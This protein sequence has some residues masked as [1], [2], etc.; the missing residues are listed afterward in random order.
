MTDMPSLQDGIDQAGSPIKLLWKPGLPGWKPPVIAEEYAGWRQEQAAWNDNVTIS[1]LSHHMRDL[2]IDG[3]DAL[4]LLSDVSANNYG[5]FEIGQGKQ[6]VPVTEQGLMIQ[7]GILMRWAEQRFTLTGPASSQPWVMYHAQNG[8]Y[9]VEFAD[10]PDSA[11]RYGGGDPKLF[12]YQIQGPRALALVE[13]VFGGPL[14]TTKFFHSAEV[15]LEGRR[16]RALRHGM[17]GQPGYEFIGDYADGEYVKDKLMTVGERYGLI[18]VGSL[19]YATNNLESGWIPTPTPAIYTS[20]ELRGYREYLPLFSFE[21]QGGIN[22]SFFSEDIEDYY[23]NPYELG[24]GRS[25]SFE[26]DFIGRDALRAR[27]EGPNRAKV[28]LEIETADHSDVLGDG[29]FLTH[30]RHRVEHEGRLV[31][32]TYHTGPIAWLGKTLSLALVDAGHATPGTQVELVWGEHPGP[33][34]APEADLGFPRMTA[35]VRESPYS[36]FARTEYR[37]ESTTA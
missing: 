33:G 17:A 10:D 18:H 15:E 14:P 22:G 6:F 30:A 21:G 11:H 20:T 24:Y 1:D 7:D 8:G 28:T 4:R 36:E 35:T 26:H 3:P 32:M 27:R 5:T 31:G 25:I 29:Y 23:C 34:T 19:A 9:D 13:E 37:K 2:F 12:R 16:F